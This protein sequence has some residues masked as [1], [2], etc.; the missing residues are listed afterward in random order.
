[1]DAYGTSCC[2]KGHRYEDCDDWPRE[3]ALERELA[4]R[5]RCRRYQLF[6]I[7]GDAI[8]EHELHVA[9]IRDLLR[10][11]ALHDDEVGLQ[12]F[13]NASHGAIVEEFCAVR[14]RD[15]NGLL[16]TE[17]GGH[18]ELEPALIAVP[19]H[20][21]P[22]SGRIGPRQERAA[23]ADERPLEGHFLAQHPAPPRLPGRLAVLPSVTSRLKRVLQPRRHQHRHAPIDFRLV[24]RVALEHRQ[25]RGDRDAVSHQRVDRLPDVGVAR[26]HAEQGAKDVPLVRALIGTLL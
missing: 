7:V 6:R 10:R 9:H 14:S 8:F 16:R 3:Q 13:S 26:V 5:A 17:S 11:V 22:P 12:A 19:G 1:M 18:E 2:K 15:R 23:G 4:E 24:D 20:D 21:G 25:R